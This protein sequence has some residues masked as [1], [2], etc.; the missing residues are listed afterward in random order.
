MGVIKEQN[1]AQ[2][3]FTLTFR[4]EHRRNLIFLLA[5]HVME[6]LLHKEE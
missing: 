4:N 1:P 6:S 3:C 5:W 2:I